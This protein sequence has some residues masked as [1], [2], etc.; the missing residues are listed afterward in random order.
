MTRSRPTIRSLRGTALV[1]LLAVAPACMDLEDI[2]Y[3]AYRQYPVPQ[4]S[5]ADFAA[6]RADSA[7]ALL[8]FDTRDPDEFAVSHL[9]GAIP[10]DPDIDGETFLAQFGDSLDGRRVVFYC[11]VG[12]R[13]SAV[14]SR[15]V[16]G[17]RERGALSLANL[18]GGLFQWY[19]EGRPVVDAAGE[20][21]AIH[22]FGEMWEGLLVPRSQNGSGKE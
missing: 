16:E 3:M 5:T 14:L 18:R 1:L 4:I 10:V 6:A 9:P 8:V 20:T 19:N 22:P 7:T 12:W 17:A 15:V 13:S 21:D 11:S 2:V